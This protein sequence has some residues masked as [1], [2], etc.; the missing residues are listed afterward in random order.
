M[1]AAFA[2]ALCF[3]F[4]APGYLTLTFVL[5]FIAIYAATLGPVTWVCCPKFF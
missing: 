1:L 3:Y 4:N 5:A 2:L